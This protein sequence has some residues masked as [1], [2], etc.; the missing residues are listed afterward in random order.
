MDENVLDLKNNFAPIPWTQIEKVVYK[1]GKHR[2]LVCIK[3]KNFDGYGRQRL[4]IKKMVILK[5]NRLMYG[6]D[7]CISAIALKDGS[8]QMYETVNDFFI[9]TRLSKAGWLFK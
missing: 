2:N 8:L 4:S 6:C 5:I 9:R 3:L 1:T 7:F